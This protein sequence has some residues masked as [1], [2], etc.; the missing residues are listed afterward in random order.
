[1]SAVANV[2]MKIELADGKTVDGESTIVGHEGWIELDDWKWEIKFEKPESGKGLGGGVGMVAV[3]SPLTF[4]K[5]MDRA[6]TGM[7]KE[8]ASVNEMTVRMWMA[9]VSD[10]PFRLEIT[11]KRARFSEYEAKFNNNEKSV[12]VDEEWTLDYR[13]IKFAYFLG[14]RPGPEVE[15]KRPAWASPGKAKGDEGSKE[16]VIKFIRAQFD[17]NKSDSALDDLWNAM[18]AE[19]KTK[20]NSPDVDASGKQKPDNDG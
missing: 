9:D 18:K 19:A 3:P 13:T 15:L 6:S 10:Q 4:S 2:L 5:L 11:I 1:M 7:L 20:R 16:E 8:M 12:S 17:L 14:D